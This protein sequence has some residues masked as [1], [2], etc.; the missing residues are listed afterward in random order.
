MTS[1]N[2]ELHG[3]NR[4]M[5]AKGS[6]REQLPAYHNMTAQSS[7]LDMQRL[8]S[9]MRCSHYAVLYID[10]SGQLRSEG[11]PSI[12]GSER[13]IFTEEVQAKFLRSVASAWHLHPSKSEGCHMP[14][15]DT[16][17]AYSSWAQPGTA[18][19]A[20]L[21]PCDL[22]SL[23]FKR[24]RRSLRQTESSSTSDNEPNSAT[25]ATVLRLGET[26]I[27]RQY[28]EKAFDRFQQLNCRVIAKA[29]IKLVEPRKQV[30]HPY[31][32]RRTS[33]S[34]SQRMDPELTKPNWWPA[35][36]TH[37]EP[38]HLFKRERIK[39][40]VH[41]LCNLKDSKGITAEK[42][43]E[44]AQDVKRQVQ[45]SRRLEVLDEIFY[46]RQMEELYLDGKISKSLLMKL[47]PSRWKSGTNVLRSG[48]SEK[49]SASPSACFS[50]SPASTLTISRECSLESGLPKESADMG[51]PSKSS[52]DPGAFTT[53]QSLPEYFAQQ[54]A[55][56]PS[57][58]GQGAASGYWA[59]I[60]YNGY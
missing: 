25:R 40:L 57:G 38:D 23:R 53:S 48:T 22:V 49:G 34:S 15:P 41:I 32:G 21:I 28:Y 2:C 6:D 8:A 30:N 50:L 27:L 43:Q 36:V 7:H 17:T 12:A 16:T 35:G 9:A 39:L 45:P 60:P 31:N 46:V 1:P 10:H 3:T 59:T 29:F 52:R 55:P 13:E 18:R 56:P 19:P 26:D 58:H 11:S 42:L 51:A 4:L 14:A 24:P 47:R 5:E 37:R 44:A 33:A 54:V 20:S